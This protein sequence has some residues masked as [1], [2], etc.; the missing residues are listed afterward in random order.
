MAQQARGPRVHERW[1]HLRFS[2]IG[3]LLAAPPR[4]GE[5]RAQIVALAGRQWRARAVCSA[6]IPDRDAHRCDARHR[7][8][9][10]GALWSAFCL[11]EGHPVKAIAV[12]VAGRRRDFFW[13]DQNFAMNTQSPVRGGGLRLYPPAP[14]IFRDAIGPDDI[15]GESIGANTQVLMSPWVMHR[16]RRFW[17]RPTAFLPSRFAGKTVDADACLYSFRRRTAHLHRLL[18]CIVGSPDRRGAAFVTLQN[19]PDRRAAGVACWARDP[20]AV[21]PPRRP[22]ARSHRRG[23]TSR[24]LSGSSPWR[25]H[26]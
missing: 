8:S 23:S 6:T 3:Q 2:V 21:A 12:T 4:K 19:L 13:L 9:E 1:A 15:C 5:L 16:H 20:P 11:L 18:V 25:E 10:L 26:A 7:R 24:A 22:A 14:H 17:D